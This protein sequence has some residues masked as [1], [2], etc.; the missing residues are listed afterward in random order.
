M[1]YINKFIVNFKQGKILYLNLL[2]DIFLTAFCG[3]NF[4]LAAFNETRFVS[5]DY[6]NSFKLPVFILL[7][8]FLSAAT[9]VVFKIKKCVCKQRFILFVSVS[10]YAVICCYKG[11][12]NIWLYIIWM[13]IVALAAYY[14]FKDNFSV[15]PFSDKSAIT[16][17]IVFGLFFALFVGLLTS[18]R[19]LTYSSPNYDF[20]IFTQ[21]FHNM[22]TTGIP[23]VT[24]EREGLITHFAVHISPIYYLILPFYFIFPNPITLQIAQAVILASGIIPLYLICKKYKI[25]NRII[26][27]IGG[28]YA[29]YP[30]LSS[31]CFYDIHENCFLTPL[32]LWALLFMEKE[33]FKGMAV[34]SALTLLVK[35][36]AAIYIIFLSIYVF[37]NRKKYWHGVFL[38]LTACFY[39]VLA[40]SILENY[41]DGAMFGR[42]GN[43]DTGGNSIL[44]VV[45]Y[46]I[47]NPA[48]ILKECFNAEKFI[49]LV[50]MLAPLGFIPLIN[51]KFTNFILL[52]PLVVVNLMP[53]YVYQ[54]S[55]DFQYIFGPLA[56]L[57]YLAVINISEIKLNK[58]KMAGAFCLVASLSL[59]LMYTSGKVYY[60]DK[61]KQNKETYNLIDEGLKVIPKDVSVA[62]NTWIIPHLY[63]YSELHSLIAV[64]NPD[65]Y[66]EADYYVFDMRSEEFH[67]IYNDFIE[68]FPDYELVYFE[69]NALAVISAD[70]Y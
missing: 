54:Y 43:Y 2:F 60:I 10:L 59:F 12:S 62:A 58:Q 69:E 38:F 45:K 34:F 35:E 23:W 32:I 52:G 17:Y 42:L 21:M 20:G 8:A 51:K 25:D 67:I 61:Y 16:C 33:N 56:F 3:A 26:V 1:G 57:F 19:Y 22:K 47:M 6:I 28:C 36:D 63:Y 24:T 27:L 18:L 64:N 11:E 29:F 50:K 55:I 31:G 49:F 70:N 5:K 13:S 46:L 41:G 65:A 37:L 7:F 9:G 30:A 66:P 4:I 53:D 14:C 68:N 40:I 39:F 44:G 48:Y 15:R